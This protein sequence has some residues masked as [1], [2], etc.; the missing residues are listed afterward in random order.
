MA[1]GSAMNAIIFGLHGQSITIA[2]GW[3]ADMQRYPGRKSNLK[4]RIAENVA[5]GETFDDLPP[6]R[7]YS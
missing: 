3:L 4:R 7:G 5:K 1:Q 6:K 2:V